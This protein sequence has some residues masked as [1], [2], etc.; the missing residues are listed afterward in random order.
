MSGTRA[1][2]LVIA[3]AAV[4][5][6]WTGQ[7]MASAAVVLVAAAWAWAPR[8][9]GP[10]VIA[11][12]LSFHI[13]Q[14]T[15]GYFYEPWSQSVLMPYSARR[16]DD[17][18]GLS[19]LGVA[20]MLAGLYIGAR[21]VWFA[22][23]QGGPPAI[24]L[25][26]T[27]LLLVYVAFVLG[28]DLLRR[29]AADM[30]ALTQPLFA[31]LYLRLGV[32]YLVLRRLVSAGQWGLA[33]TLLT[34]EIVVGATGFFSVFKEPL[35]I[36]IITLSEQFDARRSGHWLAVAGLAVAVLFGGVLWIGIR[37]DLRAD[38][39]AGYEASTV[40]RIVRLQEL[41]SRW[42][43]QDRWEQR[44]TLDLLVERLWDVYYPALA[45]ERVPSAVPH[46][47]GAQLNAALQHIFAPRILFPDKPPLP[48]ESEMVRRFAGIRVA[49]EEQGT[50]IAF[51]YTIE[52]YIDFGV[53][54]MFLPIFL[55]GVAMGVAFG[56]L[57]RAIQNSEL[58]VATLTTIFLLSLHAYNQ[59]WARMLGNSLTLA[60][61]VG[62]IVV[63]AD[64]Y[65]RQSRR[66]LR[67]PAAAE[68][69][70]HTA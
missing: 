25:K 49:G 20:A 42:W 26:L 62:G 65:L 11:I 68:T 69:S 67:V 50:T 31:L 55:Y 63:V 9:D 41:S 44:M 5:Y 47:D 18:I 4:A 70:H 48:N 23:R 29:I 53:P 24:P 57:R 21:P 51:G 1:L 17:M 14:I 56:L 28:S 3:A 6:F 52:S 43:A 38:L 45:L 58:A 13:T 40:E 59:A 36:A 12:A 60:V 19:L 16:L 8:A 15:I 64:W 46:Q 22:A 35:L 37:G 66:R 2:I 27:T 30:P 7:L 33:A 10:P 61:Y 54:T 32:L 39:Q 34:M